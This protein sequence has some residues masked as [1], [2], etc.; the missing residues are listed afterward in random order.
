[1]AIN[2]KAALINSL[3][4]IIALYRHFLQ[5]GYA[6]LAVTFASIIISM[7]AKIGVYE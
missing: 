4:W 7:I 1:L 3:N 6:F 2:S 5:D